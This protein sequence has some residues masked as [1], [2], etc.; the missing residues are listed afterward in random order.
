MRFD[1]RPSRL[2][3]SSITSL[4]L[5]LLASALLFSACDSE[6][7]G[8]P[9]VTG[10]MMAGEIAGDTAGVTPAGVQTAGVN[11]AGDQTAGVT[12]GG[13]QPAGVTPGGD[14]TAGTNPAGDQTA[15]VTLAGDQVAGMTPAG[16]QVAG[17][18]P[19]GDQVAGMTP[20]GDQPGGQT[21]PVDCSAATEEAPCIVSIYQAR[22]ASITPDLTSVEIEGV[23]SALRIND[24]GNASH[25][26][27]Q[28]PLGGDYSGIWVYLNDSELDALP[29]LNRG[30]RVRLSGLVDNYFDQRQINN[31]T[32]LEQL[33]A[34]GAI[35]PLTVSPGEVS[36]MGARA[37]ALEGALIQIV[38]VTVQDI[39]PPAGP[40]DGN[41]GPINEFVVNG[42]LRIDDYLTPYEL[43]MVGD[44]F[45]SITGILR[46]GNA[47]YKLVPRDA[48]DIA[49]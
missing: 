18:T 41:N 46:L 11:P 34:G 38:S 26:V 23:I 43:P 45:T 20:A 30:E 3:P 24:D 12:A 10:G 25:I 17:M 32:S 42:G 16:D 1:Q 19:A 21:P 33:G 47:D 48:A 39:N 7:D 37:A 5:C 8:T 28:D 44:S 14:Q 2:S 27:V 4:S 22:Q 6:E 35:T 9:L 29:I 49:R 36:T 13:D 15:G 40:G 31:V